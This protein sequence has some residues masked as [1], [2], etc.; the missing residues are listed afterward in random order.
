[1]VRKE[2]FPSI[3]ISSL[4]ANQYVARL[5][6]CDVAVGSSYYAIAIIA[7]DWRGSYQYLCPS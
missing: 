3:K 7:R 5:C 6:N 1:M 4:G 2:N